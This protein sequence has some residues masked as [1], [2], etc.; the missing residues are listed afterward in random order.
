MVSGVPVVATRVGGIPEAVRDGVDGLLVPPADVPALAAAIESIL[1][2][3]KLRDA[4][5]ASAAE[6]ARERYSAESL[7]REMAEVF[8]E[9]LA[10]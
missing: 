8:H 2:D 7:A 9:V 4:L 10:S 6:R 1:G 3:G 5:T